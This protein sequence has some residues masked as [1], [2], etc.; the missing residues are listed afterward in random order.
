MGALE[1][2]LDEWIVPAPGSGKL[3]RYKG[4]GKIIHSK[5]VPYQNVF[6]GDKLELRKISH[7]GNNSYSIVHIEPGMC[8]EVG[9]PLPLIGCQSE[10]Y[11]RELYEGINSVDDFI[12]TYRGFLQI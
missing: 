1:R 9:W 5:E 11:A 12:N 2:F 3:M 10:E 4:P 8:F 6:N 7:N